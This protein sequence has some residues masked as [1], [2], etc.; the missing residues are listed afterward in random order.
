MAFLGTGRHFFTLGPGSDGAETL[1][2]VRGWETAAV[3]NSRVPKGS[4]NW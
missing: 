2:A 3:N 1:D 4:C